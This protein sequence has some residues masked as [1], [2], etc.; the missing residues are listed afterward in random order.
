MPALS[1]KRTL[2]RLYTMSALPRKRTFPNTIRMSALCQK[3]TFGAAVKIVVIRSPHRH[4][5]LFV[6]FD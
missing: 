6:S 1:H 2:G 4:V 5:G 3:Q